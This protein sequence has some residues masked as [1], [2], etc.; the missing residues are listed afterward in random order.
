MSFTSI[1]IAFPSRRKDCLC[2]LP[3]GENFHYA[4]IP[5]W[6]KLDKYPC[7]GNIRYGPDIDYCRLACQITPLVEYFSNINSFEQGILTIYFGDTKEVKISADAQTIF[8]HAFW[9]VLSK[10]QCSIFKTDKTYRDNYTLTSDI[11]QMF[12][13]FFSIH[14]VTSFLDSP[15]DPVSLQDFES[16]LEIIEDVLESMI[17]RV[18]DATHVDS[19]QNGLIIFENIVRHIKLDFNA[20][21]ARLRDKHQL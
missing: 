16:Q 11:H 21:L 14:L 2:E 18:K 10:S 17:M 12:Y 15:Q 20:H 4:D 6:A 8:F 9:V 5:E 19:P 7:P 1:R 13:T 3:V